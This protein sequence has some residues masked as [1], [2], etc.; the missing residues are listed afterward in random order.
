MCLYA[1]TVHCQEMIVANDSQVI[2][3]A[4]STYI[5]KRYMGQQP[6]LAT[7]SVNITIPIYTIQA[8]GL[9]IPVTMRYN[10]S[11]IKV[12]DDPLPYGYGWSMLPGM[13]V[14]RTILGRPDELFE[15][16]G[17]GWNLGDDFTVT[18]RCM[19]TRNL[20]SGKG[21]PDK[22]DSEHDIFNV[23]LADG[24]YS[25]IL[26]RDETGVSFRGVGNS[27]IKISADAELASISV[28]DGKGI[29]YTF[30]PTCEIT[31]NSY[32]TA[33]ML[34]KIELNNGE[35]IDFEWL[36]EAHTP[37][38]G[39][40]APNTYVDNLEPNT[41]ML[42][43]G[44]N[45]TGPL[46][47]NIMYL[48]PYKRFQHLKKISFTGSSVE[49]EYGQYLKKIIVRHGQ[50]MVKTASFEY[51]NL[52]APGNCLLKKITLSDEGSY[53]FNYNPQ[54]FD[55]PYAQ[56]YWGYYN[57]AN[58]ASSLSPKL[59][60]KF[61]KL[62]GYTE[63][64][65][66]DRSVKS[67][68]MQANILTEVIYPTGGS[69]T[70]EY[71]PH[72]FNDP[73]IFFEST[74]HP[75]D[76]KPL[77]EGGGLRVVRIVNKGDD[78]TT[79]VITRYVYGENEDGLAECRAT[80][81]PETFVSRYSVVNLDT[82]LNIL[83]V[84][85]IVYDLVNVNPV[86]NYLDSDLGGTNIWY[87]QV[88][89][90][91]DDGGNCGKTVYDFAESTQSNDLRI[92]DYGNPYPIG[93]FKIFSSDIHKVSESVYAVENSNEKLILKNQ[94][95]YKTVSKYP[96]ATSTRI[97]RRFR[98][99]FDNPD[100][101]DFD[102]EGRALVKVDTKVP[103]FPIREQAVYITNYIPYS[104][105][106]YSINFDK[107]ILSAK[108]TT[109]YTPNGSQEIT[110]E[111][112]YIEDTELPS[113][114]V[115]MSNGDDK[116]ALNLYYPQTASE[117]KELIL[118]YE[119]QSKL[120]S[121][122]IAENQVAMPILTTITRGDGK[123]CAQ[124]LL[125]YYNERLYLPEKTIGRRNGENPIVL[126]TYDYD[127]SGNIA[128]R[129]S[130]TGISETFLWGYH[131]AYPVALVQGTDYRSLISK[132]GTDANLYDWPYANSTRLN[133]LRNSISETTPIST[134][135]HKESVGLT[136]GTNP[137]GM[138]TSYNY[139]S[140]N[141]LKSVSTTGKGIEEELSYE[142]PDEK[143]NISISS[144]KTHFDFGEN[145]NL[146]CVLQNA[147]SHIS[148]EWVMTN[149]RGQN[150]RL[151]NPNVQTINERI[152]DSGEMNVTC[153]AIDEL[154]GKS[155]SASI[156]IELAPQVIHLVANDYVSS[157]YASAWLD[158]ANQIEVRL[159]VMGGPG[160]DSYELLIDGIHYESSV[161]T[162]EYLRLNLTSGR[163]L[164]E[165]R[166]KGEEKYGDVIVYVASVNGS[167]GE[168]CSAEYIMI[169]TLR[170]INIQEL[171]AV[172]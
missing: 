76:N 116:E 45:L 89:E 145:I 155:S 129:T 53:I 40:L 154:K 74:I 148:Y 112:G 120:F 159:R 36:A 57:G 100:A 25:F 27:E 63:M 75:D 34:E 163:H 124:N 7:G 6:A 32:T 98:S 121:K 172:D 28:T 20:I 151:Q 61:Y 143:F 140:K 96:K 81:I 165:L 122:M 58:N 166:F 139:D 41:K 11:G 128:S 99:I 152:D 162:T 43:N 168:I 90:Y 133:N 13:C 95:S 85:E 125:K 3:P 134:W 37:G 110:M 91:I 161:D 47:C 126:G 17:E 39:V 59:R 114:V 103:S 92:D 56:D 78:N 130:F 157:D 77:T 72:R 46:D 123:I 104:A 15:F 50:T 68:M 33:W 9:S 108:K 21:D 147:S 42:Q 18:Q 119:E 118:N 71:E 8:N 136:N 69:S 158:C 106:V 29:R 86:S 132:C 127:A 156:K 82:T 131:G 70:Y 52:S 23:C 102:E 4:P 171:E 2:P 35:H 170:S 62:P 117:A 150:I 66:A 109:R 88:T 141:R 84:P 93:L 49:M 135:S 60:R 64:G 5:F 167:H 30:G 16:R 10:T 97:T 149:N 153:T 79:P 146:N 12:F 26:E 105:W 113:Q 51:Q 55:N 73:H 160:N 111:Y 22:Y 80:P 14:M 164:V 144:N 115:T 138:E 31:D 48:S 101:P 54:K 83:P 1:I 94:W 19:T 87:K 24:V 142:M 38:I 65:F 44:Q 67:N 107:S 137:V 169:G